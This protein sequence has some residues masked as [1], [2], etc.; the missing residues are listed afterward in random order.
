M[1]EGAAPA[2]GVKDGRKRMRTVHCGRCVMLVVAIV[3]SSAALVAILAIM[4]IGPAAATITGDAPPP[5]GDWTVT[6]ETRVVGETV[7]LRGNLTIDALLVLDESTLEIDSPSPG[8]CSIDVSALGRLTATDTTITSLVAGRGFG[9]EVRGQ[10]ELLRCLVDGPDEGVRV[11][12][13]MPVSIAS[14][15]ISDFQLAGLYLEGA[16]GTAV[17][18]LGLVSS[19][20]TTNIDVTAEVRPSGQVEVSGIPPSAPLVVN[21]G[22]PDIDGVDVS[23]NGTMTATGTLC[24]FSTAYTNYGLEL[25]C[26]LILVEGGQMPSLAHVSARDTMV[27]YATYYVF[28]QRVDIG[29]AR[30]IINNHYYLAPVLV[31]N[32]SWFALDGLV[33]TGVR[34]GATQMIVSSVTGAVNHAETKE[35][36]YGLL[37]PLDGTIAGSGA[38]SSHVSLS[39]GTF[40]GM[41]A[42]FVDLLY[43]CTDPVVSR[44]TTALDVR[45]VRVQGTAFEGGVRLENRIRWRSVLQL[46]ADIS[47]CDSTFVGNNHKSV[48][49]GLSGTPAYV[50][51]DPPIGPPPHPIRLWDNITF[52]RCT[53]DANLRECIEVISTQSTTA[54]FP[55]YTTHV[56][57]ADIYELITV[58]GCTFRDQDTTYPLIH[59]TGSPAKHN[60]TEAMLID[61]NTISD[62]HSSG[63]SNSLIDIHEKDVLDLTNNTVYNCIEPDLLS[64]L[65]SGGD[66]DGPVRGKALIDSNTFTRCRFT[67]SLEAYSGA[68]AIRRFGG[69]LEVSRNTVTGDSSAE[70][71]NFADSSQYSGTSSL[72]FHDNCFTDSP[73]LR[74]VVYLFGYDQYHALLDVTVENN[75]MRDCGRAPLVDFY[76]QGSLGSSLDIYDYDATIVV[77]GNTVVNSTWQV[78]RAHGEVSV[79]NNTFTSCHGYVLYL[80]YLNLHLPI[81]SGNTYAECVDVLYMEA[82]ANLIA[83]LPVT[84][85]DLQLDCS[86][87]AVHF[88]NMQVILNSPLL[89]ARTTPAVIAEN[90]IVSIVGG[91]VEVGSG[92]VMGP[93]SIV[94]YRSFEAEVTWADATRTD[95][96]VA[97]AGVPAALLDASGGFVLARSTDAG[98]HLGSL[99]VPAW[100]IRNAFL[101]V[102]TPHTL[103][104]GTAG[105][106]EELQV[107]LD[108]DYLGPNALAISLVDDR[109]PVVRI[110]SLSEG[111][112]VTTQGIT[113]AGF[114]AEMGSGIGAIA[115]TYGGGTPTVLAADGAG[116][117]SHMMG[118]VPEGAAEVTVTVTDVAGNSNSTTV[119]IVVDRTAPP[120]SVTVREGAITRLPTVHI[121][122]E[123]EPGATVTIGG[124]PHPLDGFTATADWAL[125]EGRNEMA[126]TTTDAAGNTATATARMLRDSIPPILVVTAPDDGAL[127]NAGSVTVTGLTE[128]DATAWLLVMR[129][130]S[131]VSNRTIAPDASG[132]FTATVTLTE[133]QSTLVLRARDAASNLNE[134]S[135]TVTVDLTPPEVEVT[136]PMSG[137]LRSSMVVVMGQIEAGAMATLNGLALPTGTTFMRTLIMGEGAGTITL[138]AVDAAGNQRVLTL[139][140][141]IDTVPPVIALTSPVDRLTLDGNVTVA[142]KVLLDPRQVT[143]S[144]SAVDVARDGTFSTVVHLTANGPAQIRVVATDAVGNTATAVVDVLADLVRPT[145][146]ATV[147]TDAGAG[148]SQNGT[149]LLRVTVGPTVD[150][151]EVVR[152]GPSGT[153]SEAYRVAPGSTVEMAVGLDMGQSSIVVRASDA[154]GATVQTAALAVERVEPPFPVKVKE[155]GTWPLDVAWVL[156][157]QGVALLVVAAADVVARGRRAP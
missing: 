140:V 110:A 111:E 66:P 137:V 6:S 48:M 146:S 1:V 148:V 155:A 41:S 104:I 24:F 55:R 68:L 109:V 67:S 117:F 156:L 25:Y 128:P 31:R 80:P 108:R 152:T 71:L 13:D 89:S 82:K 18:G 123:T 62:C 144:G 126:V 3:L 11:L 37:V 141:I 4:A 142:G 32:P 90:S 151:I 134:V 132:A 26:P 121:V 103:L 8:A 129:G 157:P 154:N 98:G 74:G 73:G 102:H 59:V 130:G 143:V 95:R 29:S 33:V 145:V 150:S 133:G 97:A 56:Q 57:S 5:T 149:A 15:V 65:Q 35:G 138:V 118:L 58:R 147:A 92:A 49:I 93:G 79:L 116:S 39:N 10:M 135:R 99:Q 83:R 112:L 101:T 22:H 21:R 36:I 17:R 19:R 70:F 69:D 23:V 125:H 114:V 45:S 16:N 120:L 44:V 27:G 53:F 28:D 107:T 105:V 50:V 81:V 87:N 77:R 122:V 127:T 124:A 52:E 64:Y 61:R 38:H 51:W 54:E 9:F 76:D 42:V 7:L 88:S 100:S 84:I 47:V 12:T 85:D 75:V 136:P 43:D 153:R 14:T 63:T 115:L 106:A 94:R 34:M 86:G 46:R 78:V 139:E 119:R 60:G 2:K 30:H 113:V 96:G 40:S 72:S 91:S 131:E 20:W